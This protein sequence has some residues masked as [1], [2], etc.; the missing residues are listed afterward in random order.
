MYIPDGK[1]EHHCEIINT[2][3]FFFDMFKISA[4]CMFLV[5]VVVFCM[6]ICNKH[7]VSTYE[8]IQNAS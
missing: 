2:Y 3:V 5:C 6:L 4:C 8:S 7:V 1:L